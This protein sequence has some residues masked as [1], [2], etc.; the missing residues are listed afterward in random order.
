MLE[1]INSKSNQSI[2][3]F[4]QENIKLVRFVIRKFFG[5]V[6]GTHEYDDYYQNGMIGLYKATLKYDPSTGNTFSTYAVPMIAWEIRRYR[7]DHGQGSQFKIPRADRELHSKIMVLC[8]NGYT[9]EEAAQELG[10]AEEKFQQVMRD[11]QVVKSIH[12][13]TNLE[14]DHENEFGETLASD[15]HVEDEILDLDIMEYVQNIA[16]DKMNAEDRLILKLRA[17]CMSQSEIAD[18]I[19]ISQVQVCRRLMEIKNKLLKELNRYHEAVICDCNETPI[20]A[21]P[22]CSVKKNYYFSSQKKRR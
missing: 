15:D 6:I 17:G 13:P 11:M 4:L 16:I 22:L 18:A 7:R 3:D 2:D 9:E 5:R 12:E 19:G 10:I 1:E 14:Q 21:K 8:G 20:P